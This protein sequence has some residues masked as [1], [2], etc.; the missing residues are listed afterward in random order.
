MTVILSP[1]AKDL[2]FLDEKHFPDIWRQLQTRFFVALL[3]RMTVNCNGLLES[4]PTHRL[5]VAL[6]H[7]GKESFLL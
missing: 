5:W 7:L 3:L 6:R 1:K 2:F 4:L